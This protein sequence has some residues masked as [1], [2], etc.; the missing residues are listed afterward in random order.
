MEGEGQPAFLKNTV[1]RIQIKG[2]GC[3]GDRLAQGKRLE[4]GRLFCHSTDANRN[5]IGLLAET[6]I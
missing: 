3:F 1:V 5:W 2:G 4:E 6:L